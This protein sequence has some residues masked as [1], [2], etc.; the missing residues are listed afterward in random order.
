[1]PS[2]SNPEPSPED[3]RQRIVRAATQLFTEVGYSLATTR[4]IAEGAGVNEVTLFRQFGSKKALLMAC[5]EAHNATGF[6]ATFQADLSGDYP[7]DIL[8]MA[9][10]QSVDM[11][12]NVE[13]LRMMLCDARSMPELRQMLLAGGRGNIARLARYFQAQIDLGVVRP[14]LTAETL[15]L[16]FDSLFSSSI[17]FEYVFQDTLFSQQSIDDLLCPLVDLFVRGS[18]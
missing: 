17:L 1:M 13:F 12:A 15:A 16:A 7:A 11:R 5:I 4:L 6:S 14:E 3:S 9:R 10:R 18:M 2:T 8:L